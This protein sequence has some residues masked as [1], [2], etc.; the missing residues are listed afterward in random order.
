LGETEGGE[1]LAATPVPSQFE[2]EIHYLVETVADEARDRWKSLT[3]AFHLEASTEGVYADAERGVYSRVRELLK[4]Y[5]DRLILRAWSAYE[6]RLQ[7]ECEGDGRQ[8]PL[9]EITEVDTGPDPFSFR[10]RAPADHSETLGQKVGRLRIDKGMTIE[11]LALS[12]CVNKKTV[13]RIINK[14]KRANP[15]TL[16][17]LADVLG[18]AASDLAS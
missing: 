7:I 15:G 16:K 1:R 18:V 3:S 13:L 2:I 17:K 4:P 9:R 10:Q 11:E 8:A 5:S 14:G 6:K 12:A